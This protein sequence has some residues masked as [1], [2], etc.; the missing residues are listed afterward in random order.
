[1]QLDSTF[2][3]QPSALARFADGWLK[4][5]NIGDEYGGGVVVANL[6][7]VTEGSLGIA[8]LH[9]QLS[10]E[11]VCLRNR[12]FMREVNGTIK[13]IGCGGWGCGTMSNLG[14]ISMTFCAYSW[15]SVALFCCREK[16][17]S[18]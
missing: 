5:D 1:M 15:A 10:Q 3:I 14:S 18:V 12:G 16:K 17:V 4:R 7:V 6:G 11:L 9:R 13:N 8:R 2:S